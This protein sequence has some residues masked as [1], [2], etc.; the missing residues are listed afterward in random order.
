MLLEIFTESMHRLVLAEVKL[1][2]A[3]ARVGLYPSVKYI[4]HYL[5]FGVG[6]RVALQRELALSL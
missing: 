2:G 5:W 3:T 6:A 1:S 4:M